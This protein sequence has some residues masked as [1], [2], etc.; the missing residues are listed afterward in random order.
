MMT[1][2]KDKKSSRPNGK[3]CGNCSAPEGSE[4][5]PKL[6]ACTRCGLVVYCSKDCQRAHWKAN[7]KQHCISKADRVPQLRKPPDIPKG[8][9]TN[10]ALTEEKCAICQDMLGDALSITL[11][12]T[13]VFHG[14]C[15]SELRKYGVQQVCPL[16]RVSLPHGPEN[17]YEE[18]TLRYMVI[19]RLVETGSA[20]WSTL[21]DWAQREVDVA[22]A[23]WRDAADQ[24][25]AEAQFNLGLMFMSGRG[26][27]QS[28]EEAVQ[29]YRKA[30]DQGHAQ[31]QYFLGLMF[32]GGR[33]VAQSDEEAVQ[34]YRKAADQG[35][36]EAQYKLGLMF[37]EGRGVAQSDEKAVQWYRKAADQGDAGAQHNVGMMFFH[38][39]GVAQSDVEAARWYRTAA[40][41]GD[42][43]AQCNLGLM[44][45]EGRG[46][47]QS[48]E[49]AF[50]WYR[51]AAD[52][53]FA[54]AQCRLA[55]VLSA[56][57]GAA[58]AELE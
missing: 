15:V 56:D 32:K 12:C 42:A 48:D 45:E 34:W 9:D 6:S 23:G 7:H 10:T 41:Q 13:H 19:H 43:G 2:T 3:V 28:D 58:H 57:H 27:A 26:M 8:A 46:V 22:I 33:G 21:P 14:P 51:K 35:F 52:Q 39:R 4:S 36:A 53:G 18:A 40:D 38:G 30:A 5:A 20:S 50:Q 25:Y 31:A 11:P 37:V 17:V 16:C 47:A 24:E 1:P 49:E 55:Q 44:F 29:W 54:R